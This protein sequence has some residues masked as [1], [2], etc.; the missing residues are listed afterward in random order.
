VLGRPVASKLVYDAPHNLIWEPEGSEPRYLHR[1]GATPACGPDAHR[2]PFSCTGHPVII[3]GS[4][5]D[6]SYVL[7]GAGREDLL[8][9]ACHGAGR[10]LTR[11]RSA[12][13][14]EGVYRRAVERLHVVT[15]LDPDAPSV[16]CRRDIL[17]KYHQRMKEEAPYAYKPITP[18]VR[19]VE[20][21]GIARRVVKLWPLVTVKG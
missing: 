9:S 17:A 2:S 7:A 4:M 16:R 14:E 12:H 20:D 1:K 3:P 13:V 21:A 19:S 10:S 8:E 6:A 11:G 5:G 18:V 15:P